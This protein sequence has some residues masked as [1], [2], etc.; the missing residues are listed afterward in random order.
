MT[1]GDCVSG[2]V[3]ERRASRGGVGAGCWRGT[4]T[5]ADAFAQV[6][7]EST[8]SERLDIRALP[9][10]GPDADRGVCARLVGYTSMNERQVRALHG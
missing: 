9:V 1:R 7:A 6:T 8:H 10:A 5:A 4:A 2:A 3:D